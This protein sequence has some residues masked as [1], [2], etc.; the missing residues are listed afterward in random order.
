MPQRTHVQSRLWNTYRR[1]DPALLTA[2]DP[3]AGGDGLGLH[4]RDGRTTLA[5]GTYTRAGLENALRAYGTLARLGAHGLGTLAVRLDLADPYRPRIRLESGLYGGRP[6][7][8]VELR[9]TI[10]AEVGLP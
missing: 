1:L 4:E 9:E 10:G 2:E 6:C 5:F 3:P 7:V 8:D